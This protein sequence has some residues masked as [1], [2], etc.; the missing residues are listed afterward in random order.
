[1]ARRWNKLLKDQEIKETDVNA[2][3][4]VRSR[5]ILNR[6]EPYQ[7]INGRLVKNPMNFETV[8]ILGLQ[9]QRTDDFKDDQNIQANK[10]RENWWLVFQKRNKIFKEI[11]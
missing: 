11:G 5:L 2:A 10:Y 1:M 3:D 6:T 8:K 9:L 7:K 4:M